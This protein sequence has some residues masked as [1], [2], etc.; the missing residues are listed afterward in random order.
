M[1][2]G[3]GL[4][5]MVPE[6]LIDTTNIHSGGA[7][8]VAISFLEELASETA[9]SHALHPGLR[10]TVEISP[11]I[12]QQLPRSAVDCLQ[13]KVFSRRPLRVANLFPRSRKY[14]ISFVLFGPDYCRR[15][16]RIRIVGF[17]DVTAIYRDPSMRVW[18]SSG[19]RSRTRGIISRFLHMRA[20][21]LVVETSAIRDRLIQVLGQKTPE[22]SV[23]PNCVNG[24]FA[25]PDEWQPLAQ[26]PIR[27]TGVLDLVY[28]SRLY[29]HKNHAIL[30]PAARLLERKHGMQVRFL[31]TLRA[32]EFDQLDQSYSSYFYNVGP[33]SVNQVPTLLSSAHGAV[34][35]SLLEAFSAAPIEALAMGKPLMASDRDFVRATCADAPWYF[36]PTSAED[37]A[38]SIYECFSGNQRR[39]DKVDIGRVIASESITPPQRAAMYLKVIEQTALDE[40]QAR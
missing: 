23:V 8:Q 14:D 29:P 38:R 10:I 34:F 24:V 32:D 25:R 4:G 19:V 17:A 1:L 21:R 7:L 35:P 6:V 26:M 2:S 27:R 39:T 3:Q 16:A 18:S 36:E 11:E 40:L 22:I 28:V 30:G 33:L 20:D 37:L 31:L 13:P 12:D 9:R 5:G 15:R